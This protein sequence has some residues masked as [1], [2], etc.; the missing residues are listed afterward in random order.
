VTRTAN[1][2]YL[3][4]GRHASTVVSGIYPGSRNSLS[5]KLATDATIQIQK[6]AIYIPLDIY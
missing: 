2:L 3:H 1:I 4:R 6:L 5:K